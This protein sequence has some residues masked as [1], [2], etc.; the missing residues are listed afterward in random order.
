MSWTRR[1]AARSQSARRRTKVS[2]CSGAG[3]V[4]RG[5]AHRR[6]G[7]KRRRAHR[8]QSGCISAADLRG[9]RR[10]DWRRVAPVAALAEKHPGLRLDDVAGGDK[11]LRRVRLERRAG[12]FH[13]EP[14][15]QRHRRGR[16][17]QALLS[18]KGLMLRRPW[19]PSRHCRHKC[20]KNDTLRKLQISIWRWTVAGTNRPLQCCRRGGRYWIRSFPMRPADAQFLGAANPGLM[21]SGRVYMFDVFMSGRP[22]YPAQII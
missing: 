19:S 15:R 14:G 4:A 22:R 21:P 3:S 5:S 8:R 20:P 2:Q 17:R 10:A 12:C 18:A 16:Q 9:R 1:S 13:V 11:V 7:H 6:L